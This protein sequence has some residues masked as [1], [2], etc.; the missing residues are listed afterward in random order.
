MNKE[1]CPI[2]NGTGKIE[3]PKATDW[4]KQAVKCL[5][6]NGFGIR[7]IQR[8]LGYKSPQSVSHFLT[9]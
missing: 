7:Q 3:L 4:K 9:N 6:K 8:I 1:K 2:C 5:Y